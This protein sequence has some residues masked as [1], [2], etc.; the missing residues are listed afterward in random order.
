[1]SATPSLNGIHAAIGRADREEAL[2][3]AHAAYL[4][5]EV[6]PLI[7]ALAAELIDAGG[8][9][10]E[11]IDLTG[12]AVDLAPDEAELWRR[13]G[14]LL[15]RRG[16]SPQSLQAFEEALD[17]APD[18][19]IILGQ[20]AS[21]ALQAGRLSLA[22]QRYRRLLDQEREVSALAGLAT[23]RCRQG[24]STEGRALATEALAL[25]PHD[26]T[27]LLA[28]ARAD[29]LDAR[30][31]HAERALSGA[32]DGQELAPPRRGAF[33]DLRAE[34]RDRA[35]RY[36]DAFADYAARN[37]LL[38]EAH[39]PIFARDDVETPAGRARR[40]HAWF[41]GER[42]ERWASPVER[43]GRLRVAF[44]LG[45]PRSGTTLLEKALAGHSRIVTLPEIDLLGQVGDTLLADQ[46]ALARL[47]DLSM[48]EAE[49]LRTAYLGKVEA[50]LGRPVGDAVLVDK[51]PLHALRLPLIAKLFP[52]APVWLALRDPRDVVLSCFRRRF[53]MNAAMYEFL[54]LPGAAD[55]YDAV[56]RLVRR[57]RHALPLEV[58][59]VRLER[60]QQDFDRQLADIL[61]KLGLAWEDGVRDM[62]DRA[63][64]DP[65]TP[66]DLQLRQGLVTTG[67]SSWRDYEAELAPVRDRV[68]PWA[69]SFGYA[70]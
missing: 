55:F 28:L 21:A 8:G 23:I 70:V 14:V 18:N 51:M 68:D 4:R 62:A 9:L 5:G 60:V 46:S 24:D 36:A 69:E 57:Y 43:S 56:M 17:I 7:L 33:L 31:E 32:L 64:A 30:L 22:E 61:E 11:A 19:R 34:V 37:A 42:P 15:S 47:R 6:H 54:T 50:T 38:R 66:S 41:T 59:E 52:G 58:L 44:V 2:R 29:L 53:Q 10:D 45:F 16:H 40:L 13:Y 65:G 48:A 27:A 63:A 35:G 49:E 12:R 67:T 25:S 1:M 20:A 39:A 3:L 26:D